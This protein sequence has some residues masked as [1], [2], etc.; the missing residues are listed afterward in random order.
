M[1]NT[2]YV[3]SLTLFD[4]QQCSAIHNAT[5]E[6]LRRTG[7]RV[8]EKEALALLKDAGAVVTDDNLVKIPA[9]CVEWALK[10]APSRIGLCA[11]G[12]T[13]AAV[14]L[15]GDTVSFGPGSDCPNFLDP[16]TGERRQ[17]R[18][19]DMIDCLHV[20]DGLPQLSFV[21]SMGIPADFSEEE[22]KIKG[23]AY[24]QQFA[25][26]LEHSGKPIVFVADTRKDCEAI[27]EMAAVTQGGIE[28]LR[29]N[30]NLLL[31]SEPSSPLRHSQ[32]ATEKLLFMAEAELPIVHSPAQ[33]MGGTAPLSVAGA[34]TQ[35]NA[36]VLSS[37]LIHQ[38]KKSGAPF[39]YGSGLHHMDMSTTISVYGAPEFQ[40]ARVAVASMGKYY[41]LP[42]WGY[43][44]HTDS[45][46]V[47]EQAAADAVFSVMI[48]RLT[49]TNLIHDVGYIE[50]GLATS[51]EMMVLTSEIIDMIDYFSCGISLTSEA[52][53]AEVIERVGPGGDH[54]TD[55][56]TLT[57]F[58]EL[59]QPILFDRSRYEVWKQHGA[60]KVQDRL[61]EKTISLMESHTPRPLPDKQ[62][63]EIEDVLKRES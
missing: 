20:A 10:Q 38:L 19:Q 11:R 42:T 41:S 37:L 53:A 61:K 7:V 14:P 47:D 55:D 44:G 18:K 23:N 43:S 45:C 31:Y 12:S 59:W 48:A 34:L 25:L 22:I 24:R 32:T 54:L 26:M 52:I 58:R 51:P 15:E 63:Q 5:L 17:F 39:V 16:K 60:K 3:P 56:Y 1:H 46:V 35:G 4:E 57:H 9:G 6:V 62:K 27:A 8:Y 29:L 36:E 21:M 2:H 40:L 13:E 28:A 30:P 50:G 49:G 33:M